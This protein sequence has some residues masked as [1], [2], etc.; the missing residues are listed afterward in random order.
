MGFAGSFIS[1]YQKVKMLLAEFCVFDRMSWPFIL[2]FFLFRLI[3]KLN[4]SLSG[5]WILLARSLFI[6]NFKPVAEWLFLEALSATNL[7]GFSD[8]QII[9]WWWTMDGWCLNLMVVSGDHANLDVTE[10][11]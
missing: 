8:S 11:L 2:Q 9:V 4:M 10:V 3:L 1:Q 5:A 6:F 7:V